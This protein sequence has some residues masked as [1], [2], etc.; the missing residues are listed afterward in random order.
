MTP[1]KARFAICLVENPLGEL[2]FLKRADDRPLGAGLWG[3]PA[4]HIEA[5]ESP[6]ECA[7]RELREETGSGLQVE[8]LRS[9]GPV[10]DS[11]YGGIY[12]IHL[13]HLRYLG[14]AIELNH[15]HTAHRWIGPA[16]LR[17]LATMD[18]IEEDIALL[19]IWP[20][21]MLDPARLPAHLRPP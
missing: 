12:E 9:V 5:Q 21:E 17:G 10:R 18:G 13:F 16:A 1:P 2:L 11:F 19:E 3:F 14:G 20:R 7:W 6:R 8:E 15:E 4:G